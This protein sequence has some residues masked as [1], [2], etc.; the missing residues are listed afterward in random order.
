MTI[1]TFDYSSAFSRNL[2]WLSVKDQE[3][4]RTKCVAIA[5]LGG[6]GGYHLLALARLGI[7]R[8][9]LAEF[10][11]VELQNF[12]RQAC[13]SVSTLGQSK[14]DVMCAQALDINPNI[15][16]TRFNAPIDTN[17]VDAFLNGVDLFMD[18]I[19]FFVINPKR[20]VFMACHARGIPAVTAGPV[21]MGVA[22][23]NFLPNGP[24]FDTF[25]DFKPNDPNDILTAK[26][27]V[28]LTP[29]FI[30][31]TYIQEP[32]RFDF[33][34]CRASSTPQG[35]YLATGAGTAQAAKILLS[36]RGVRGAPWVHHFDAYRMKFAR[37]YV[38][39]GNR[40]WLQKLKIKIVLRRLKHLHR[41]HT[42]K[43]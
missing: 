35:C 11:T 4:L 24:D 33:R 12:N 34:A 37:S 36:R 3:T 23:I 20:A 40:N 27:A 6:V 43:T 31:M 25:F 10:D 21:G 29:S 42:Q 18:G 26:F 17:N 38:W 7:E 5:G 19:D 30:H 14:L 28:G 16:I 1:M 8:F 22:T 15:Q 39:R 9:H 32:E 2:G 41:L 13:A